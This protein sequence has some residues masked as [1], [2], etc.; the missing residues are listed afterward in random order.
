MTTTYRQCSD[1]HTRIIFAVRA[2]GSGR[3]PPVNF[4]PDP[5]GTIAA[6]QD[7]VTLEWVGRFLA[8]GEQPSPPDKRYAVHHCEG[9]ERRRQHHGRRPLTHTRPT[10]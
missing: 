8:A 9:R 2:D 10:R 5:L 3:L 1:C 7:A 4:G 6:H